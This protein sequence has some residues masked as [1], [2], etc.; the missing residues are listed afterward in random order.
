MPIPKDERIPAHPPVATDY[1]SE[2]P[3]R[4]IL[5]TPLMS[6]L[7]ALLVFF[8][9]AVVA[10]VILPTFT[11]NPPPSS[12]WLP[13]TDAAYKGKAI[14]LANGCVYC[15]SSFTRPEDYWRAPYYLYP[16]ISEP[17]DY[18]AGDPGPN[19]FGTARTGPDLSQEGG[20]HP[21]DWQQAHYWSPRS[22]TPLSIMP[23]FNF[24]SDQERTLLQS[25]IQEQGGKEA[26]LRYVTETIGDNLMQINMGIKDPQE[27]YPDFVSQVQNNG[28]N[29]NGSPDDESS[30]GLDWKAV[31]MV[32]SFERGYW[33]EHDPLVLNE[34]N[35]LRGKELYLLRCAGC[36]GYEGNGSGPAAQFLL[37]NPF[38]FQSGMGGPMTSDGMLYHRILTAGKGTAMENFGTRLSVEDTWRIVLFLRTIQNGSLDEKTSVPTVGMWEQWTPPADLLTYVDAHP[39]QAGPGVIDQAQSDPFAA[40]AHWLAPGLAEGDVVLVGGKLPMSPF[41]LRNLIHDEYMKAVQNAFQEAKARGNK[42]P[43]ESEIMSTEGV[44][45][46]IP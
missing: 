3:R 22:T 33:L 25:F 15:H 41:L 13:F 7:G 23:R 4:V 32:N 40:A 17:G 8:S 1:M 18:W 12:N 20:Q 39:I 6:T 10:V 38:N 11:M 46:H 37:P 34:Q 30:W 16:R 36:H 43:S 5:M 44:E 9:V 2:E 45:F 26:V 24:L 21:D 19:I 27:T 14:Y 29:T 35:L 28:Y 31:W 42:L